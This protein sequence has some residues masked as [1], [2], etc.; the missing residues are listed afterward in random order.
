VCSYRYAYLQSYNITRFLLAHLHVDSL[1]KK[2]TKKEV[3]FTLENLSKGPTALNEAYDKAIERIDKQP[4]EDQL[5]AKRALSW[6]TYAQRPLTTNELR[7]ALAI[8]PGQNAFNDDD[9]Y[10][11]EDVIPVCARLFT[12]DTKSNTIRL[13]HY[14]TQDYLKRIFFQWNS[15]AQEE[16]AVTCLTYLSFNVFRS[17]SCVNDEAFEQ[18]LVESAF[19]DYSAHYWSEHIRPVENTTSSLALA[20]LCNEALVDSTVQALSVASYKYKG[21]SKRFPNRSNGL[22]LVARYGLLFLTEKLLVGKHSNNIG[23]DS[24]DGYGRTPLSWA[25]A[26]GH[27]AV[28]RLLVNTGKAKIDSR[29]SYGE[30]PLSRAA[31]GGHEAVVRLLVDTG[32]AEI[33]LKDDFGRT[34]LSLAAARGHEAV[35][36]LLDS[37]STS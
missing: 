2:R 12:I 18:R 29:S 17:G 27:E 32:K 36:R 5:L 15:A 31:A 14:T 25:A 30:T 3:L 1:L 24:R 33:D 4:P 8:K 10:D 37:F 16:I 35:V 22:H 6:I 23:A 11:V 7:H 28:V 13:V 34:P 9:V 26:R 19:F 20:F 21:F